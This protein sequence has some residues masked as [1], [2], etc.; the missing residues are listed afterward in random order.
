MPFIHPFI[1]WLGLAAVAAPVVI[2]LL[3]R[4]R[5][6]T[7]R[8]AAM[9]FL[10]ESLRRN[11][12][13]LKVEELLL[14]ALR[15]LAVLALAAGLARYSG[16]SA[17]EALPGGD[18]S[19]A[20]VFVLDDSC[21]MGQKVGGAAVFAQAT[22]D[23]A[24]QLRRLPS[25]AKAAILLSSQVASGQPLLELTHL[26]NVDLDALCAR[27]TA[28]KVSATRGDLPRALDAAGKILAV[29]EDARRVVVLSDYRKV[30][31]SAGEK[32]SAL[33]A[34][35]DRLRQANIKVIL[36]DFGHDG[37]G[38]LGVESLELLDRFAVTRT[39]V[40]LLLT[41]RNHGLERARDVEVRL[42]AKVVANGKLVDVPLPAV[43]IDAID[44]RDVA[45]A[46]VSFVPLEAGAA[47][48][49]AQLPAD[50]LEGD[51]TGQIALEVRKALRVLVVDGEPDMT[52]SAESESFAF[53]T[54][55]D[56][57]GDGRYG[58][59]AEVITPDV[60]STVRF[61][62]Y[63]LVAMLN[64]AELPGGELGESGRPV[65]V[66]SLEQYVRAGG[67]LVMFTGERPNLSFYNG[68]LYAD[69]LGLCPLRMGPRSG[70]G[71]KRD[72]FVRL[73]PRSVSGHELMRTFAADAATLTQLVRFFAF[74]PADEGSA[75]GNEVIRRPV[76]VARFADDRN[77]PA[78]ALRQYGQ[79]S[80]AVFYTTASGRWNDWPTDPVGT[81]VAVVQ[82]V[83]AQLARRQSQDLTAPVGQ[84]LAAV[85]PPGLA[86]AALALKMPSFPASEVVSLAAQR[87]GQSLLAQYDRASEAGL[88]DLTL[89]PPQGDAVS[90]LLAR[91]VEGAEGDLRAGGRA[92]L[93]QALGGENLLYFARL[94][95]AVGEVQ[96]DENKEYWVWI[97]CGV[98]ALLAI[99]TVLAQRFGHYS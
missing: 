13:R 63:D 32:A 12:R 29:A 94:T 20:V 16:C 6:R 8:W 46:E 67:G 90:V 57:A 66:E 55:L 52:D 84:P 40:R 72:T 23:L 77:S 15:C 82:D 99:E 79:G 34:Q 11:R 30:D 54:A 59:K 93:A 53:A 10:L 9:Q 69:G 37:A 58:V 3:N 88:Y 49:V 71:R 91:N 83:V 96:V 70:D 74:T 92:D 62:D 19:Q 25:S 68:L 89:T 81:Y 80:V 87:R 56:P 95:G 76:V 48:V 17:G 31:L 14:L 78:V 44:P 98:L 1:F 27:L 65:S 43:R 24:G 97:L 73:D 35:Y 22:T 47:A 2:H 86:D 45:R 26:S 39:P 85:I 60:L 42:T 36:L 18:S 61:G 5:F 51:N 41:V 75:A 50:A 7:R 21:S 33:R 38:N 28:L 64:V 4:R